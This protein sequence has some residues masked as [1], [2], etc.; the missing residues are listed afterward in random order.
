MLLMGRLQDV[1]RDIAGF[2]HAQVAMVHGLGED[3]G[4]QAVVVGDLLG[5]AGLQ[6]AQCRQEV[7]A[8]VDEAENVGDA[9]RRQLGIEAGLQRF[10]LV[11]PGLAPRQGL[12]FGIVLEVSELAQPQVAVERQ[13]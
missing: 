5:V 1:V 10:L 9:P 8:L 4:H 11:D 13:P 2:G 3:H 12:A 7:A 6:R